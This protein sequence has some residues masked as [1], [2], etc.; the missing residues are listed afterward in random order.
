L[1][2]GSGLEGLKPNDL[3][4][5]TIPPGPMGEV[6]KINEKMFPPGKHK[7]KLKVAR[8]LAG[9]VSESWRMERERL[10]SRSNILKQGVLQLQNVAKIERFQQIMKED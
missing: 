6:Y 4:A 7:V 10:T 9:M 1:V 3:V 5:I 2:T 8:Q